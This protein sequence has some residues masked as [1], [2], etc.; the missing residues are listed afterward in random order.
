M[1]IVKRVKMLVP[2]ELLYAFDPDAEDAFDIT[3]E[4]GRPTARPVSESGVL[5]D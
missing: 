4:R 3:R 2:S 1:V 5:R